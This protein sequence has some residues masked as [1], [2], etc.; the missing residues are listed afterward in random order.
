M[1]VGFKV[2][3]DANVL[4]FSRR[5]EVHVWGRR[6]WGGGRRFRF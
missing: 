5:P 2:L 6:E 1:P 4:R 3:E